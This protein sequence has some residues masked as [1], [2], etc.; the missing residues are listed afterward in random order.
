MFQ[1]P[2]TVL[3]LLRIAKLRPMW[4]GFFVPNSTLIKALYQ[5]DSKVNSGSWVLTMFTALF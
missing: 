5:M 3:S 4:V 1:N 2:K